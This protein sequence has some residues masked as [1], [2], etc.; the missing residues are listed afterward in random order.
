MLVRGRGRRGWP[1]RPR[2]IAFL[3]ASAEERRAMQVLQVGN[4]VFLLRFLP[5]NRRV[6]VA[7]HDADRNVSFAM[8]SLPD[9][10]RVAL[11]VP[12][13]TLERWWHDA[14]YGNAIAVHPD[15]ESCYIA[16]AGRL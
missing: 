14:W 10:G 3:D 1:R 4:T 7:T 11:G 16:W 5:D 6:V 9:G 2:L 13:A 15:G 12:G 8:L